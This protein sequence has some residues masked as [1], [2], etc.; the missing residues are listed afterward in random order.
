VVRRRDLGRR[1]AGGVSTSGTGTD[2]DTDL[3]TTARAIVLRQLSIGARTREQLKDRLRRR[4]IPEEICEKV[5]ERFE[6]LDLVDDAEFARMWVESRHAGKGLARRALGHEL[7]VR[8]VAEEQVREAVGVLSAEDELESARE[9][10][11]KRVSARTEE[12]GARRIR[13]LAAMLSRKGYGPETAR[14][15]I[16]DVLGE[17]DDDS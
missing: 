2:G 11:R 4:G 7:R 1:G 3:E 9:L 15:A 10:V 6:D 17:W 8:G 14:R 16:V 5:L 13:R 12:E